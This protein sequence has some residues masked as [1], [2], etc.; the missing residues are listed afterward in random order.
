M[1][2]VTSLGLAYLG[3]ALGL[4]VYGLL[5]GW[6]GLRRPARR[7]GPPLRL[8][9]VLAVLAAVAGATAA[10]IIEARLARPW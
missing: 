7:A 5:L 10:A 4:M 9:M 3:L 2:G 6:L 8:V 1:G